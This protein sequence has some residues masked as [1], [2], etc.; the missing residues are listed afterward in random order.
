ME[1]VEQFADGV[2]AFERV[3]QSCAVD[4][5]VAIP[6]TTFCRRSSRLVPD[7]RIP[8]HRTRSD[9]DDVAEITLTK[10]GIATEGH[11]H[12][13]WFVRNVHDGRSGFG[14]IR[15]TRSSYVLQDACCP[16]ASHASRSSPSAR[17]RASDPASATR[18]SSRLMC[19]DGIVR[20]VARKS[21]CVLAGSVNNRAT[22]TMANS[23][24]PT[25]PTS[26]AAPRATKRNATGL[27]FPLRGSGRTAWSSE[28]SDRRQ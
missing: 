8:L 19:D 7:R 26:R 17:S 24:A 1:H 9:P 10:I 2:L 14:S 15:V 6:T 12:M 21:R 28:Q 20:C 5:L 4:D 27:A 3:T 13:R 16:G 18:R 22:A 23:V 11:H 25:Q